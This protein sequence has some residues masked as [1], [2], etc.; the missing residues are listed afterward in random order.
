MKKWIKII[1]LIIATPIILIA[2][3]LLVYIFINQQEVIEPFEVGKPTAECK[4]LIASQGSE[5]KIN[6]VERL[7]EELIS[8]NNYLSVVDCTKLQ[9]ENEEVW[10][11]III[12]HTLQVHEMPE[13]AQAFL[14]QVDDLSKVMLV[15]TSGA[16]DDK[17]V[18]FDVDAVSSPSRSTAIDPI[19]N[20]ILPKIKLKL[21][22][23]EDQLISDEGKPY[24]VTF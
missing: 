23:G 4:I 12:I 7:T 15:S 19:V 16:G 10:D 5:F 2:T 21:V 13:E 14:S 1:L 20:W 22:N 9:D 8:D 11:A 3:F 17:V 24:Y 6:L 18:G